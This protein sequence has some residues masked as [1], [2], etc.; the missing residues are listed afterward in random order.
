MRG[1]RTGGRRVPATVAALALALTHGTA[2]PQTGPDTPAGTD[3][4]L[5]AVP[6]TPPEN[7]RH[8]CAHYDAERA[9]FTGTVAVLQPAGGA[10][11]TTADGAA[12]RLLVLV[13]H[14]DA[15]DSA[16]AL[17]AQAPTLAGDRALA[18]LDDVRAALGEGRATREQYR[19]HVARERNR[20][21]FTGS[22]ARA[23]PKSMM[24]LTTPGLAIIESSVQGR[25]GARSD[26]AY[27]CA[28]PLAPESLPLLPAHCAEGR[29]G[30][31]DLERFPAPRAEVRLIQRAL[32]RAGMRPGPLDGI[33]GP[34]TLGA[35]VRWTDRDEPAPERIVTYETLCPLIDTLR[36]GPTP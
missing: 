8:V 16:Q 13:M 33:F 31:V 5:E 19:G 25:G 23:M 2:E 18:L 34:R 36:T 10:A 27:R 6:G 1:E 26:G 20:L 11:T 14:E 15:L 17:A 35:L 12:Y 32:A 28:P 7:A 29:A 21:R 30:G 3:Q 22:D 24:V 9:A 4:P